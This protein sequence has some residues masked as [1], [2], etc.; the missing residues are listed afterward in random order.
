MPIPR[1]ALPLLDVVSPA[2]GVLV[3][4][5]PLQ[6]PD[7]VAATVATV[8]EAQSTWAGLPVT[9][10]IRWLFR[11]RD[12]LLDHHDELADVVQAESGKVRHEARSEVV[13][14]A[15]LVNY[16]ARIAPDALADDR[17][18]PHGLLGVTKRLR[19]V[20][21]PYGVVGVISPWNFPLA[22]A[23][24]DAAPALLAGCAVVVKPSESTPLSLHR[25]VAGWRELGA[26]PVLECVTGRAETGAALVDHV[27]FVQFTGS[28]ATGRAVAARA[29]HRLIPCGLELGGKDP[30][31]VLADADLER[32]AHGAAWGGLFNAGQAC[33]AVERV[34]V[35]R[36]AHDDFV[37]LLVR[38]V[39]G[40]SQH[41]EGD[42]GCMTTP[43]QVAL[44]ERQIQQAVGAGARVLVGGQR[45]RKGLGF[46]P[47]VL[48]DVHHSMDIM[49]EESF[50]PLLP[51][52]AV[53]D[54]DEAVRL[55]NDSP[56]GL[57]ASVWG[58]DL[59]GARAVASRLEVGAVN[60]NDVMSNLFAF[61][62]PMGGWGESGI[63]T[64]FGG[65]QALRKYC[66]PQVFT[67]P[68]LPLPKEPNW[69][70]YS[71]VR[72]ELIHRSLRAVTARGLRRLG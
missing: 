39:S 16:L 52:M 31:I 45:T 37:S 50:G 13:I 70:P 17:P 30:M 11:F 7:H 61:S 28:T 43:A 6:S 25:A 57:S 35:E 59:D 44:V 2:R 55:A 14:V 18:G 29:A 48:V 66:R 69:F 21:R 63:G 46:E 36:S 67:E 22:M 34:Y 19:V 20:H 1:T 47:T 49:R 5:V 62:V 15:D 4:S 54:A 72:S 26:P 42:V 24:M 40:L 3:G 41:S 38:V 60:L 8:R 32:A 65:P 53:A 33:V 9:E 23:F 64:R 51:V 10:R 56:Y 27:D 71:P 68:R 58:R 12:W